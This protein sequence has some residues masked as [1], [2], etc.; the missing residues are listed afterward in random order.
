MIE[1]GQS[2]KM[3]RP[4]DYQPVTGGMG[5]FTSVRFVQLL[6]SNKLML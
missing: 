4:K 3:R 2:L 6:I 5:Q 1:Q